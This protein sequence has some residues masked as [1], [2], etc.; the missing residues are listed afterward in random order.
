MITAVFAF[1]GSMVGAVLINYVLHEPN[2]RY[3]E[4]LYR[5]SGHHGPKN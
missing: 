4:H 5:N 2:A 1:I 3:D